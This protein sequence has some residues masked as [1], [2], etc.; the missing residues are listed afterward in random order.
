MWQV[1]DLDF[2]GGPATAVGR[3]RPGSRSPGLG[4][5]GRFGLSAFEDRYPHQLSG[6]MRKRVTL[7][8]SLIT[9]PRVLLMDEPFPALDAQ[10]RS[11]MCDELTTL[12]QST[13]S[14]VIFVTHGL[15]EAIGLADRVAVLTAVPPR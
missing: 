6:G 12:W 11:L 8:Q 1:D 5:L 15:E 3:Q 4:R 14:A 10:T 9:S 13:G 2:G 7:A